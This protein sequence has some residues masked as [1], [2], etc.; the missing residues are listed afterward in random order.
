MLHK[1]TAGASRPPLFFS[2]FDPARPSRRKRPGLPMI[3]VLSVPSLPPQRPPKILR[4][5]KKRADS[6][7]RRAP[8]RFFERRWLFAPLWPFFDKNF[9][10]SRQG[11]RFCLLPCPHKILLFGKKRV[12][13]TIGKTNLRLKNADGAAPSASKPIVRGPPSGSARGS[14]LRRAHT[15]TSYSPSEFPS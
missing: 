4:F 8:P 10:V 14:L 13:S 11:G 5:G 3:A 7:I 6:T 9:F 12:D 2:P 1:K 15:T